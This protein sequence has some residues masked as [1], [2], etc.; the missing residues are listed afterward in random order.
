M[1]NDTSTRHEMLTEVM[2]SNGA[3][4]WEREM[5]SGTKI[6]AQCRVQ[7]GTL[8][9][10]AVP[11]VLRASAQPGRPCTLQLQPKGPWLS[12]GHTSVTSTVCCTSLSLPL[13]ASSLCPSICSITA[14]ASISARRPPMSTNSSLN[15][16][17]GVSPR[18]TCT[19][20]AARSHTPQHILQ[21]HIST[22]KVTA[23]SLT[24]QHGDL[25]RSTNIQPMG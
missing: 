7:A 13:P 15:C 6:P 22:N 21:C 4:P 3:I 11:A 23:W 18:A 25:S 2:A 24:P 8:C 5:R 16:L 1:A 10:H 14:R 9:R 20:A 17:Y 19:G 12:A